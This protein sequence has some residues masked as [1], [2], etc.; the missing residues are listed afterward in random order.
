[1]FL[2]V[3]KP[4]RAPAAGVAGSIPPVVLTQASLRVG[5]P[6]G[7][8]APIRTGQDIAITGHKGLLIIL[9]LFLVAASEQFIQATDLL[10]HNFA[11]F[12]HFQ[13]A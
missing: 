1:M 5:R 2:H 9:R 4:D 10:F 12:W 3:C 13:S 7:V 6:T 8:K 11:N